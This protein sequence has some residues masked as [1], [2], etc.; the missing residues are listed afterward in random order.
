M[1]VGVGI[2]GGVTP[3][4]TLGARSWAWL[5]VMPCTLQT[6]KGGEPEG[7][8]VSPDTRPAPVW[9]GRILGHGEGLPCFSGERQ[10]LRALCLE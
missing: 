5:G 3:F 7:A 6:Q 1:G 2:G 10:V 8:S 4:P 9:V